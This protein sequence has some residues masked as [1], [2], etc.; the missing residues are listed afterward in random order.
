MVSIDPWGK[1]EARVTPEH[2]RDGYDPDAL[3]D[4]HM[5]QRIAD[6]WLEG[7]FCWTSGLGWMRWSGKHWKRTTDKAVSEAIRKYV[8]AMHAQEARVGAKAERLKAISGLLSAHRIKALATLACG[9]LEADDSEFDQRPELLNVGNGVVDLSTGAL[10]QH[11][12]EYRL[13]KVTGVDYIEGATHPDWDAA[14]RALPAE[15]AAWMQ[16]RLGQAATGYM[17]P[18]DTLIVCHGGGENGKTTVL[19]AIRTALG[20]HAV[21]VPERALSGGANQ[22]PTELMTL[23]G[24]RFALIEEMPEEGRL[25]VKR[26]K[27]AV[28]T[29]EMTAR[30]IRGD[31]I[32][33]QA[34]HSLFLTTNY[35]PRVDE[36]D[37]G[38]WRRLAL[39]R[40]PFTFSGSD[41]DPGL[42]DRLRFGADGQHEAVLA[43][44]VDGA[45]RWYANG[46]VFPPAPAAVVKDTAAWR[47]DSD[48]IGAYLEER[49]VFKEGEAVL[50]T[51]LL[52][53]FN[54]WLQQRGSKPWGDQTFTKRF[55]AHSR[56]KQSTVHKERTRN[57]AEIS[58]RQGYYADPIKGRP[59]VWVG[60]RFTRS[61]DD[62]DQGGPG[63]V[64]DAQQGA[65]YGVT[66]QPQST[67]VRADVSHA[68]EGAP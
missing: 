30:Y 18:D 32:T 22:H 27:D 56:V 39:V 58:R 23:F 31:S 24:A 41:N 21:I 52:A 3:E 8:I 61:D 28:G 51:E 10:L 67:P 59:H 60:V 17:T 15:V 42:R 26:L 44:L 36:V 48:Q 46:N 16:V 49:I 55:E 57:I 25:G 54:E 45:M 35:Q 4:A 65:S 66:D 47:G 5:V 53:D 34:T 43:W 12:P 63:L 7:R 14:L 29:P 37:H 13:T 1:G 62:L 19:N 2:D 9:L 6:D 40:F 11:D 38:T 50:T 20:D 33:W 68:Q 64:G